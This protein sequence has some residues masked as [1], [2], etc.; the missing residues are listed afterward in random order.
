MSLYLV[1]GCVGILGAIVTYAYGGWSGLLILLLMAMAV[2]Y[3]SGVI[4][5]I[6]EKTG[7]NSMTG[8]WGLAKKALMLLIVMLGHRIDVEFGLNLVMNGAI[9]FYLAN[10]LISITE[11]CSRLGLPMPGVIRRMIQILKDKDE[12]Q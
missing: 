7:L 8:F 1:N 6:K 9:C 2:D 5:S 4:A 10:E 3:V 11:N 12:K